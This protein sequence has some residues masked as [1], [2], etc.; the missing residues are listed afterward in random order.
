MKEFDWVILID[1][2]NEEDIV[3]SLLESEPWTNTLN[4]RDNYK[5]LINNLNHFNYKN[6]LFYNAMIH[7]PKGL[8][9]YDIDN[10]IQDWIGKQKMIYKT[11]RNYYTHDGSKIESFVSKHFK[12]TDTFL[13][14][15]QSWRA[16]V[17][18]RDV[19]F[20]KMFNSG[21]DI[22]SSPTICINQEGMVHGFCAHRDFKS[23]EDVEWEYIG[24]LLFKPIG[25]RE[26]GYKRLEGHL[27]KTF[28]VK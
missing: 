20:I 13:I 19:G 9:Y 8:T 11:K 22:Y 24:D 14:G 16:C 10:S 6:I 23:D 21:L 15:G 5:V 1:L 28:S 18:A 3:K 17:H 2:W 25:L 27:N 7:E 4:Y 26:N 12:S